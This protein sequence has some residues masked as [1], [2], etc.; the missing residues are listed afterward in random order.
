MGIKL[1][2]VMRARKLLGKGCKGFLCHAVSTEDAGPPL[3]DILV[4]REFPYVFPDEILGMP[5]LREVEFCI[6]LTPGATPISKVPYW[7]A[8]ADCWKNY[9]R[10]VISGLVH[11]HGEPRS[12]YEEEGWDSKIVYRLLGAE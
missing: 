7:M 10:K 6:D 12:F 11:L 4:V 3:D 9:Y 1:V 2:S 5:P 8:P